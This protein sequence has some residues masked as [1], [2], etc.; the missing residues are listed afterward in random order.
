M[1]PIAPFL[2]TPARWAGPRALA[3]AMPA[4]RL[5][6]ACS[7]LAVTGQACTAMPSSIMRVRYHMIIRR[8]TGSQHQKQVC[9]QLGRWQVTLLSFDVSTLVGAYLRL[10]AGQE[11][12]SCIADSQSRTSGLRS[13]CQRASQRRRCRPCQGMQPALWAARSSCMEG[14]RA[15]RSGSTSGAC[16]SMTQ[17]ADPAY[18]SADGLEHC[19]LAS[20]TIR[21]RTIQYPNDVTAIARM[22]R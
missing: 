8:C 20:S 22:E 9:H 3:G 4:L 6:T 12:D 11:T 19:L 10:H 2:T 17:V 16:T 1:C 21:R 5:G 13:Q 7:S 18:S 15:A 14:A